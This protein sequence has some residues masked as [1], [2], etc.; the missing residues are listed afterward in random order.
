MVV[1]NTKFWEQKEKLSSE[2]KILAYFFPYY[3]TWRI[4]GNKLQGSTRYFSDF[5]G[6]YRSIVLRPK[7]LLET[8][9]FENEGKTSS[10]EKKLAFFSRIIE[11]HKCQ[12]TSFMVPQAVLNITEEPI[13]A[14]FQ[15]LRGCWKHKFLKRKAKLPV[16]KRNW[17]F[18]PYYRTSQMSENIFYCSTTSSEHYWGTYKSIFLGPK[19]LLKTQ[20][21]EKKGQPFQW[22][23]LFDRFSVLPS[24][25]K[26]TKQFVRVHKVFWQ[27]LW[28]L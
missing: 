25:N 7:R 10:E 28:N 23:K 9:I 26:I 5:C 20:N 21:F 22:K 27:L 24:R 17:R 16:K 13:R 6:N 18:L 19:R 14:F 12:R 15:D 2:E 1:E 11:H 3:R 4:A 8:Q